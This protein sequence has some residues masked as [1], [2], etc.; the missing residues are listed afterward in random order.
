MDRE[1]FKGDNAPPEDEK[2][3]I[4]VFDV[5]PKTE[6][7]KEEIDK[8]EKLISQ[9]YPLNYLSLSDVFTFLK[10][11]ALWRKKSQ[12]KKIS[13]RFKKLVTSEAIYNSLQP[14]KFTGLKSLTDKVKRSSLHMVQKAAKPQEEKLDHDP[15]NLLGIGIVAQFDLMKYLILAFI[16]VSYTHLTLPTIC[17][18]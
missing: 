9:R 11:I 10:P 14:N 5:E 3:S 1:E 8:A 4:E 18:V 15:M 12:K 16:S 17:S 6:L 2:N 13:T 7:Q